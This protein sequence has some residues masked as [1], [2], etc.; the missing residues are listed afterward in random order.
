[1][2]P[3]ARAVGLHRVE[4]TTE[5]DNIASRRTIERTGGRLAGEFVNPLYG[6]EPKLRY[7]IDL[8]DPPRNQH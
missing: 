1:M 8:A 5:P 3:E 4:L 2:L 6:P 7:V